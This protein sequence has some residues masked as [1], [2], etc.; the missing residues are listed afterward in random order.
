ML[1]FLHHIAIDQRL[2][3]SDFQA[4]DCPRHLHGESSIFTSAPLD[5]NI[6][7]RHV[8]IIRSYVYIFLR[9]FSVCK[10]L[11]PFGHE[12]SWKGLLPGLTLAAWSLQSFGGFELLTH[13]HAVGFALLRVYLSPLRH[14]M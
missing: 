14:M 11:G 2:L 6:I 8:Y 9:L 3:C 4:A 5:V 1:C 13:I 10:S 12:T 7:Y